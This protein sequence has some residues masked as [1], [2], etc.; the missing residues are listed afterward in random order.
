MKPANVQLPKELKTSKMLQR[1]LES[2]EFK[3]KLRNQITNRQRIGLS[4]TAG[5]VRGGHS[6]H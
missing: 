5:H 2:T 1:K 4:V 6:F 3:L